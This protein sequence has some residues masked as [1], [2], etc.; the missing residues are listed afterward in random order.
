MSERNPP[1]FEPACPKPYIEKGGTVRQFAV[2]PATQATHSPHETW[3][4]TLT[5]APGCTAADPVADLDDLRHAFV[6]ERDR[7]G[8][9]VSPATIARSRSQVATATGRTSASPSPCSAGASASRASDPVAGPR[10]L[11]HPRYSA[12][13]SPTENQ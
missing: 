11:A 8:N 10:E 2:C 12:A 5:S 13:C 6:S 3:N 9:G 7:R 4:G 1:Q